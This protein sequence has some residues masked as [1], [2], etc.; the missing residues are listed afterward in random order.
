MRHT[1]VALVE[2]KPGVLARISSLFMRRNFN[3]E[4]IAAGE[5]EDPG[6]TRITTVVEGDESVLEQVIS[7]LAKLIDVIKVID[8]T[9]LEMVARE[10]A[11]VKVKAPE[12]KR[13]GILDVVEIFRAKVIDVHPET[14]VIEM[15]GEEQK[16]DALLQVLASYGVVEIARTGR[17]SM[18]RGPVRAA[19]I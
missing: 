8:M 5:T 12:E 19:D 15:S 10:L 14:L 9:E 16:V 6:V 1:I 4:S 2:N 11:L 3:I 17:L 7:Q 13:R 18:M